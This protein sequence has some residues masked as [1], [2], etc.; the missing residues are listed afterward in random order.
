M[1]DFE[2]GTGLLSHDVVV[3]GSCLRRRCGQS[4]LYLAPLASRI[5]LLQSGDWV[6]KLGLGFVQADFDFS[7]LCHKLVYLRSLLVESRFDSLDSS[8]VVAESHREADVVQLFRVIGYNWPWRRG[9][10]VLVG[11]N[12]FAVLP[13]LLLCFLVVTACSVV[14]DVYFCWW[15]CCKCRDC[16][17]CRRC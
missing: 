8:G 6:S 16:Y 15:G 10:C 2:C 13:F 7:V 12:D 11:F 1:P 14:L 4:R 3:V 9:I 17:V 5:V